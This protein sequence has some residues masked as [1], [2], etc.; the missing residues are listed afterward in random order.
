MKKIKIPKIIFLLLLA[1]LLPLATKAQAPISISRHANLS[2]FSGYYAKRQNAHNNGY[3]IGAY[4]DLPIYRSLSERW[5]LGFWGLYV[6]SKWTD[7]LNCYTSSSNDFAV[8][9]NTGYY[10]ELFSNTH[11]F[12]AGLAIGY[13]NSR[14]TGKVEKKKYFSSS[15]QLDHSLVANLNLNLMKVS[16]YHP[17]LFPR[18]QLTLSCQLSFDSQKDLSE[19]GLTNIEV[20]PWNKGNYE[21]MLKQSIVD[22]PLNSSESF[23]L[24]PKIG[25][26]YSHYLAGDPNA[27]VWTVELAWH[28][29]AAD[30]F[31]SLSLMQKFYPGKDYLFLMVNINILKLK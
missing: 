17:R 6:H 18:T 9:L 13:K 21:A 25:M 24:Q 26:Q 22:I 28:K 1:F 27:Y 20:E 31:L 7:N 12:F 15:Q 4:G 30:D 11:S 23:F 19:N 2:I 5:N 29:I 10:E 3:W 16:G 8:G 14:E